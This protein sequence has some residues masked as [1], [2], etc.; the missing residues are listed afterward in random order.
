MSRDDDDRDDDR[1]D[2][3]DDRPS[4]KAPHRATLIL[5]LGILGFVVCGFCGVAAYFMGKADL[6]EMD[7]GRMDPSG[8][9]MTKIGYILGLVA[10]ILMV[11]SFALMCVYFIFIGAL[12]G[13]GGVK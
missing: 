3:Y 4:R 11:L 12:I 10:T 13:G 8:R 9:D 7:A 1:E 5:I 6:A 2:D